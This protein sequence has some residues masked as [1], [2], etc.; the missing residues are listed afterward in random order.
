MDRLAIFLSNTVSYLRRAA[1]GIGAFLLSI[2]D[3][4]T[5]REV[6]GTSAVA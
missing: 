1:G 2:D 3:E 4:D 5:V 6:V